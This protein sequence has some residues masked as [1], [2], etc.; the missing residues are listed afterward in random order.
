GGTMNL[1]QQI[2]N[3]ID[4]TLNP[5]WVEGFIRLQYGTLDHLST[6]DFEREID[7]FRGEFQ[8][9]DEQTWEDNARSYG[10]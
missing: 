4:P 7:L 5:R 10:L 2:I 3:R 9:E 8:Q 6:T 1:Y